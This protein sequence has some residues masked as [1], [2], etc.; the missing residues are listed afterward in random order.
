MTMPVI[1]RGIAWLATATR[2]EGSWWPWWTRWLHSKGSK[3]QADARKPRNP[4][5]PAPGRYAMMP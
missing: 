4:I 2:H 5:E 1:K 3:K